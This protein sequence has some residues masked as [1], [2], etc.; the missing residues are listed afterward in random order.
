MTPFSLGA[1]M[2]KDEASR[3]YP[4]TAV[5][6]LRTVWWRHYGPI[7][8]QGNLGSC[9]GNA[10]AQL[11][12][13]GPWH[14]LRAPYLGEPDAVE[15][16]AEN[17]RTDPFSGEYPPEDTGSSLLA[18]MKVGVRHGRWSGYRWGFKGAQSVAEMLQSGPV[19]V[20]T[21]WLG[22]MFY[23]MADG[24]L[25]VTG[26][27]EGGHCYYFHRLNAVRRRFGMINSWG[28]DWGLTGHAWINWDDL[29]HLLLGLDGEAAQPVR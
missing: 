13:T 23:P 17:T 10:P 16:Y 27:E 4:H 20:A 15:W 24:T 3:A 25:Q 28:P 22:G 18:A 1:R 12:N 5:A 6:T 21:P 11:L 8:D 26:N 7:L 19:V 14:K 29:D 2:H 9:T